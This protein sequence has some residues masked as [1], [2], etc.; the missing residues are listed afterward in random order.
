MKPDCY[1][2]IVL[3]AI[4]RIGPQT[5]KI[6]LKYF[7][8]AEQILAASNQELEQIPKIGPKVALLL[9]SKPDEKHIN[10]E[11]D[12]IQKND[13][14]VIAYHHQNYPFRL[15]QCIDAPYL[16]YYKG[17]ANL[18]KKKIIGIVGSRIATD[19]GKS[20]IKNL[21][22]ELAP[23]DPL[24]ISGLAY[25]I[26]I[27]A[28][29]EALHNQLETIGVIAHGLDLIYP[30]SHT[31]IAKEMINQGGLLTEY[32]I[33]LKPEK[34]FFPARN[35]IIAGLCEAIVVVEA[36]LN[37]GALITADIAN[38]Y[39]REVFALPGRIYDTQSMGCNQLIKTNYAH[40]INSAED[41]I[42][43]LAW[44]EP[45]T[46]RVIQTNFLA[47]LSSFEQQIVI[48][49]QQ[50]PIQIDEL[51]FKLN[52]SASE[53]SISLTNLEIKGIISYLPGKIV[54]ILIG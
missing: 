49:L 31:F 32:G 50:M 10:A 11:L 40:L 15:K 30:K 7:E 53:L 51:M 20:F 25:G 38:S 22:K 36:R 44:D 8:N 29:Q 27:T 33:G 18:G 54:R 23:F 2:D 3:N 52:C 42:N 45:I 46:K 16:M 28:H 41:L 4:P 35:R 26:D 34:G 39:D 43:V 6:L 13:I 9:K 14:E 5:I 1:Y 19:Y 24:I 17:N 21:V 47:D 12:F 48:Q 37:G